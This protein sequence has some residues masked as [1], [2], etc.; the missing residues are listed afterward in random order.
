MTLSRDLTRLCPFYLARFDSNALRKLEDSR[1]ARLEKS[2]AD[3]K[4]SL[5]ARRPGRF[6]LLNPSLCSGV[7]FGPGSYPGR[8]F[9]GP[10]QVVSRWNTRTWPPHSCFYLVAF[11][12]TLR[13]F[14]TVLLFTR[15][16]I[17]F[18]K[19]REKKNQDLT[20]LRLLER[21]SAG[22]GF[23]QCSSYTTLRSGK[24]V[25]LMC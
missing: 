24:L 7:T 17:Y 23:L 4:P 6:F 9:L 15:A 10:A 5:G 22:P 3:R 11:L 20:F 18:C 25:K 13:F 12:F 21:T 8:L 19:K 16:P 1:K 2:R 14:C